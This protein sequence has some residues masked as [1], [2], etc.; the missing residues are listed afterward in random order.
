MGRVA[1]TAI[2]AVESANALTASS[3]VEVEIAT[4]SDDLFVTRCSRALGCTLSFRGTVAADA[5]EPVLFFE[6]DGVDPEAVVEWAIEEP[7][8]E[9]ATVLGE[10][11]SRG[12]VEFHPAGRTLL[13]RLA[14]RGVETTGLTVADGEAHFTL[15]FPADRDTREVLAVVRDDHPDTELVAYRQ[16]DRPQRTPREIWAEVND[17]LTPRQQTALTKAYVGG[18]FDWPRRIAG[19]DLADS[20]GITRSTFH[21][22]LRAAE[23]KVIGAFFEDP[24]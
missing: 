2:R 3:V 15:L 1:G 4:E 16:R 13:S 11:D 19:D 17:E 18:F 23:A 24:N 5:D 21:Q 14:D 6:V 22:H 10:D 12:L 20:M 8:L 9:G 7:V